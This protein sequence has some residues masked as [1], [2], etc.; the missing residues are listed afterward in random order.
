MQMSGGIDKE[1]DRLVQV[2]A[3]MQPSYLSRAKQNVVGHHYYSRHNKL[4]RWDLHNIIPL[5]VEEHH[6]LHKGI[7]KIEIR[8]PFRQQY[9]DNMVQKDYK[10]YLLEHGLTD[11]DFAKLC[12]KRLKEKIS[13]EL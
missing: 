2:W 7:I 3:S 9:L 12:N 10:D 8:N 4:L 6:D 11:D 5:T 13:E 1:N